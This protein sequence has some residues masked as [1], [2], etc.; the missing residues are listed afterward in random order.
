MAQLLEEMLKRSK[1]TEEEQV[2]F[3]KQLDS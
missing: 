1:M 3:K 2:E